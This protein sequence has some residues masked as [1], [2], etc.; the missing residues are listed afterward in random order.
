[1][2]TTWFILARAIH[3]GTCLLFF[4]T[5]AFDRLV[6]AVIS[7]GDENPAIILAPLRLTT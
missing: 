2:T 3:F 5:F 4:G 7:T 1:M 6:A